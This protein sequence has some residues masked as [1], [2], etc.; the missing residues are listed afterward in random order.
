MIRKV[1]IRIIS[2]L[3]LTSCYR[4]DA[5]ESM[6]NLRQLEGTW[7]SSS[8]VL[9]SENWQV[10]TDTLMIGTGFSLQNKDTAFKE[11]L[12]IFLNNHQVF[13]AA[14]VGDSERFVV[15]KLNVAKR[16][17][18]I[19]ENYDHDYPNII[20]YKIDDDEL[21][22]STTNSDGHKKIEFIMKRNQ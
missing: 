16:N 7:S 3:L 8:G 20:T 11:V 5:L 4:P 17:T 14:K 9:F 12:K 15:F 6:R 10:V 2:L 1:L 22:A 18:W 19:F 21:I 13:Y